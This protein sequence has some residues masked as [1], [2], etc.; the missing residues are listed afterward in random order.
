LPGLCPACTWKGLTDFLAEDDGPASGVDTIAKP[1]AAESVLMRVRGFEVLSEIAR[2]GMG[3]VYRA[4]QLDPPRTIAL[5]MLLPHQ[6]GSAGMAERFRLEARALSELEHPAILPVYQVGEQ[7][8]L[9]FF[10]MKLA[11]GGTL[12]ERKAQFAGKYQAIA[13]LVA[14]LAD[15]VQFAHA[16]GVLHRDIKPG[17]VLFDDSDRPYVSD[18]GL[19]KL[20][21]EDAGLTRSVDFLGTPHYVAPEIAFSSAQRATTASDVYALGAILHEL[22][23]GKPPFEAEGIPAL[24]KKISEDEPPAIP[25]VPRDL[26]VIALECLSK[27]PARRYASAGALAEDLRA[28]LA[29]RPIAARPVSRAQR[30]WKWVRRNPGL[31][32]MSAAL[33]LSLLGGGLALWHSNDQLRD[34]LSSTRKAENVAQQN[35]RESLFAQARALGAAHGAGQRWQALDALARAAQ[36][37]PSLELRNEAAAALARPDLREVARFPATFGEA[38]SSAVFTSD[39]ERY[40]TPEPSGG[41]SLR[42]AKDQR[43]LAAFP[44][45]L[46]R[47]ARWFVLSHDDRCVGALLD[48]Y[49]L[50]IWALDEKEPRA[51]WKG[52]IQQPPLCEFSPDSTSLA[53]FVPAQGVFL[54][55]SAG[56]D[57]PLL[58]LTNSRP[59][60]LRFDPSGQ[61]LGMVRD[62]GG[63]ELISCTGTPRIVWSQPM[64]RGVPWLA[65]S[66][67][68]RKLVAASDD[69]RG[70]R[71]F[72]ANDGQI[73]VTFSSHLLYPRQFEV[74]P[75]GRT[76]A[77]IGQD[78]VLRLW[79]ARTGQEL[80]SGVGRHRVLRFSSDGR[81]LSTAPTDRELAVLE[82]APENVFREFHST[83]ASQGFGGG[84]NC[85]AD[86]KWLLVMRPQL[87]IY[88]VARGQ[89]AISMDLPGTI[90]YCFFDPDSSGV[91]YSTFGWGVCHRDFVSGAAP[92][93]RAPNAVRLGPE[94]MIAPHTNAFIESVAQS[95][96]TWVRHGNDGLELWVERDPAKAKR[97]SFRAAF[98]RLA[99]SQDAHWAATPNVGKDQI[100]VWNCAANVLATNLSVRGPD[101]LWF[102]PDSRFLIAAVENGYQ[103]WETGAWKQAG[104]WEAHLDSGDPGEITFSAD[105]KLMAARQ[106]RE[107]FRLFSFPEL[108]E[109]VTLAPPLVVPVRN[110]CLSPDGSRLWL[111]V[112]GYRLFEW[113]LATLHEDLSKVGL[114]WQ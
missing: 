61:R 1:A 114:A 79:D 62:P 59:V 5:K 39:L 11:T 113:N 56:T 94:K 49:S 53:V 81:R 20:A 26:E 83:P 34:A 9:P 19:A 71:V 13:Q 21:N 109:L 93:G 84:L 23:S 46:K 76:I 70:I 40:I 51:R 102:S 42:A 38:G 80:V 86:G 97:L 106:Q 63:I 36:L 64:Q 8:G 4:R 100:S 3:I 68:G 24:L 17:N 12:A 37:K 6:L 89:E 104:Q 47:P 55:D 22:L 7:D 31:A 75:N 88:D 107:V 60:F 74:H 95:G 91:F 92:S 15:A 67:D 52:T 25:G 18:F 32:T 73:E 65:W 77:S 105:S 99:V 111:L 44:G 98:D 33:A 10:T 82:L 108:R 29:G 96:R 30:T 16:H 110:A 90:K 72:S 69:G 48:D 78:W 57:H 28:W 66:P 14:T 45:N 54:R 58:K 85:S 35:L 112:S 87:R 27:E 101:R 103:M 50:E 2:G 41:F 43:V